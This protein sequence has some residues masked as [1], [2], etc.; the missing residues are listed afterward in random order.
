LIIA[1]ITVVVASSAIVACRVAKHE[2]AVVSLPAS[3]ATI[4][5]KA[6]PAGVDG[7]GAVLIRIELVRA[8]DT[9]P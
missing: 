6:S 4:Q 3:P 7:S 9:K 8:P 1:L 2:S 5:L